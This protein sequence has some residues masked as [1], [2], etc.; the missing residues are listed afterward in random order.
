M[1]EDIATIHTNLASIQSQKWGYGIK[2]I[3]VAGLFLP[4][5]L[6]FG[7]LLLQKRQAHREEYAGIYKSR[8]A[9]RSF[10]KE[11][12]KTG[13]LPENQALNQLLE[14]IRDYI[15]DRC[16]VFGKALTITDMAAQLESRG[17][18]KDLTGQL[19]DTIHQLE[20][21]RYGG[22]KTQKSS[23]SW[24]KDVSHLIHRI[25]KKIKNKQK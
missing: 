12:H 20:Y 22:E 21:A 3:F 5:F 15:G 9:Y 11:L 23:S 19:R 6:F 7:T 10:K 25:D 1:A 2:G 4:P 13:R 17:V 24:F 18:G 16:E 8:I 14:N